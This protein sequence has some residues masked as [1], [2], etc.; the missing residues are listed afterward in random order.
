[1]ARREPGKEIAFGHLSL[2]PVTVGRETEVLADAE[3]EAIFR[4]RGRSSARPPHHR[5]AS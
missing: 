1:M 3:L 5:R 2:H 4:R